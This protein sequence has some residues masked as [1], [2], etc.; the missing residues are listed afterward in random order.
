MCVDETLLEKD[1][2]LKDRPDKQPTVSGASTRI[3]RRTPLEHV[4]QNHAGD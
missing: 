4:S 1:S 2:N 3:S